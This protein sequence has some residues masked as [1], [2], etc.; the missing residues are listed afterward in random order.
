MESVAT[1]A[2]LARRLER[3]RSERSTAD[4]RPASRPRTE[5][6]VRLAAELS[7]DVVSTDNGSLVCFEST[8]NLPLDQQILTALPYGVRD[9]RPLVCFDLETTGLATASGTLAFLAGLGSWDGERFTVRQLLL[10]DHTD[11][12]AFLDAFA[13]AI[14]PDAMLVTYNGRTFDWPLMVAR[15]RVHR[16]D[17]P[18]F[19]G[20][21]DLLPIAR[22]LWKHRLGGARLGL[23]EHGICGVERGEDL[24]GSLIPER[25]FGY[26]RSRRGGELLDIVEHNRQ[27][28]VSLGL[29][30]SAL[31]RIAA[32]DGSDIAHPGDLF[33]LA[34]TYARRNRPAD[35][36]AYVE[37]ALA[38]DCWGV[39]GPAMVALHRQLAAEKARLLDR[40]GRRHE[41]AAAWLEIALRGGPDA[42]VAWLRVARYREHVE[43]DI[44]GAL[45]ASQQAAAIAQ[46]ARLWG[47]PLHSVER[48]LARRLPRLRRLS[49]R[50]RPLRKALG[51]A[52]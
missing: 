24:P 49:F 30:L 36:L 12:R 3:L 18:P 21:L 33:G 1:Q 26:L 38:M 40:L 7:G 37:T 42:G 11:E 8:V 41:S 27:D 43:R 50:R 34:R 17:P 10:A 2:L 23:V 13:S 45:A 19:S 47:E 28:I 44:G 5:H 4:R 46:R 6:A 48:D 51:R 31:A 52:A 25:Y 29:I 9:D 16:R 15:Y 39:R 20:H 32:G 22:Q 14:P 35:A